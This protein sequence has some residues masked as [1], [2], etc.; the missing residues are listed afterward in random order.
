MLISAPPPDKWSDALG[1]ANFVIQPEP[2]TPKQCDLE[3]CKA[4]RAD[5][6]LARHN[7]AKH[8]MRVGDNSGPTSNVYHLTQEKWSEIDATWKANVD[9]CVA[10]LTD[11]RER[12]NSI[13]PSSP[14]LDAKDVG[15]ELAKTPPLVK[16]PSL[17]GPKSEGKF[18]KMGDEGIVGPM[19]V[20]P[21]RAEAL[22]QLEVQAAKRKR[23]FGG[24]IKDW[25][26]G[27][28]MFPGSKGGGPVA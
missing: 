25:L 19:E 26:I 21:I 12:S 7:Y 15:R 5:W 9:A 23:K 1:H 2:Y 4:L 14:M 22:E 3:T 18:P 17:N 16:I 11:N 24:F 10:Q 20:V 28:G 8:L 6:D 13:S 27:V